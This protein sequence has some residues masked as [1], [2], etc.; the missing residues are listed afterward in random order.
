MLQTSFMFSFFSLSNPFIL[1]FK[2][3]PWNDTYDNNLS[4][5]LVASVTKK[6]REI[7]R[8]DTWSNN[9]RTTSGQQQ[10]NAICLTVYQLIKGR[11]QRK[12]INEHLCFSLLFFL[13]TL[14]A[15][16]INSS[17]G[18]F[19]LNHGKMSIMPVGW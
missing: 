17:V 6:E 9:K 5:V 15:R 19:F 18:V 1:L 4:V 7:T 16:T 3:Y 2:Q 12:R 10:I 8:R 13:F 11:I 14:M